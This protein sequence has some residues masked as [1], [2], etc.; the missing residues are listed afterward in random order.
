MP[1]ADFGIF[2]AFNMEIYEQYR[3]MIS[4]YIFDVVIGD[5]PWF[6]ATDV[7]NAS[8][9]GGHVSSSLPSI[10]PSSFPSRYSDEADIPSALNTRYPSG[11]AITEIRT[12]ERIE[13][14]IGNY[15]NYFYGNVSISSMNVNG[16][17]TL[18]FLY[19]NGDFLLLPTGIGADFFN[20]IPNNDLSILKPISFVR[21]VRNEGGEVESF[22]MPKFDLRDPP[23]FVKGLKL[24]DAP[25]PSLEC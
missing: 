10:H 24:S 8:N 6:N 19:G 14:Y 7:C 15:G 25:P 16:T 2:L 21:F 11:V 1:D 5:E 13:E 22:A 12:P 9:L 4:S 3:Y 20:A 17:D 18:C 23:R